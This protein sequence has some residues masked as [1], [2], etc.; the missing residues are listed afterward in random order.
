MIFD[1]LTYLQPFQ[2][3]NLTING[4]QKLFLELETC[5][6]TE[7]FKPYQCLY[8]QLKSST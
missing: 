2:I 1:I 5:P 8:Y 3:V 4:I 7:Q 6:W